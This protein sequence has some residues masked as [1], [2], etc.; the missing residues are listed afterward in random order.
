MKIRKVLAL[1]IGILGLTACGGG[2]GGGEVSTSTTTSTVLSKVGFDLPSEVSAVPTTASGS[3][4]KPGLLSKM[5]ALSAPTDP[6]TDYSKATTVR[7]VSEHEL[8]QAG[9]IGEI[10][11]ALAQTRYADEGNINKGPYLALVSWSEEEQGTVV[12]RIESWVVDSKIL[13]EGGKEVNRV[14]VWIDETDD[15]GKPITFKVEFKIFTA[16]TKKSDGS[17]KDYGVWT[18]HAKGDGQGVETFVAGIGVGPSGE[19]VIKMR[20]DFQTEKVKLILNRTDTQGFGKIEFPDFES[21]T[22]QNC[23]PPLVTAS[24]AYN[25]THLGIKKG[26]NPPVFKDRTKVTELTHRYGIFD[27]VTG[28]DVLRTKSFGFPVD[29][30]IN[31]RLHHGHYGAWQGRHDL[32]ADG[33][34]VPPGTTVTRQRHESGTTTTPET[35]IVSPEFQ[36][37]LTKRSLVTASVNDLL[38]LPVETHVDRNMILH[39]NG[40]DFIDCRNMIGST[41][42]AG[43]PDFTDLKSL[44]VDPK[45]EFGKRVDIRG[46]KPVTF[47]SVEYVYLLS[48][49]AGEGFYETTTD[50]TTGK[51]SPTNTK[52]TPVNGTQLFVHIGGRVYIEF[53]LAGWVEKA[54]L[55]F[56]QK[57]WTPKFDDRSKDKPFTLELDR[58][59]YIHTRG[60]NFVVKRI[61]NTPSYDV[62]IE[63]QEAANPAN[64]ASL[65]PP[66][67]EFKPEWGD[68][69]NS[70][71]RFISDTADSKF[72]KLVYKTVGSL[73]QGAVVGDVVKKGMWGLI[74]TIGGVPV[75]FNW[76]FPQGDQNWGTQQFL[77]KDGVYKILDNPIAFRTIDLK[78]NMG[79]LKTLSLQFDGWMHGLPD[80]FFELRANNFLITPD[81]AEKVIH[82]PD[83]T[84]L[85]DA[86]VAGQTYLVKP[87]S[88]EQFLTVVPDPGTLSLVGAD[89]ID[90]ATVPTFVDH[91]MGATPTAVLKYIEGVA[92]Q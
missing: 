50:F 52:F 8:E 49:P 82:I 16:A 15:T 84:I 37:V 78:N 19:T 60:A 45:D 67:T 14:Q 75:R 26:G 85:T 91:N 24:Y 72:L 79:I 7:R 33:K 22:S 38:K 35:Y 43:S 25:T 87:L 90:L 88:I 51:L 10:L 77:I 47:E 68:T 48:G 21:C 18:V 73:D 59:Y 34:V 61:D 40:T 28:K 76:E 65:I 41:C 81:I 11:A 53:T 31:N 80:L 1:F 57:T 89:G 27:G 32:W 13:L 30:T 5:L 20:A 71:F 92:V 54:L 9:I 83:G 86:A 23:A 6:T 69:G 42:G 74:A 64:A 12:K 17:Y 2:G 70:T 29:I 39:H 46:S 44:I 62:R 36:G 4:S 55:S 3:S 66:A 63:I 58:E 56:D